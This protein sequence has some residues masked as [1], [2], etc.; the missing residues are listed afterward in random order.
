M[1][2]FIHLQDGWVWL[3]HT[4]MV[5]KDSHVRDHFNIIAQVHAPKRHKERKIWKEILCQGISNL[6]K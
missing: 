3:D 4:Q 2:S 5:C 6:S 1:S